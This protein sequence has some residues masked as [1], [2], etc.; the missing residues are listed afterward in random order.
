MMLFWVHLQDVL[1]VP[2]IYQ[3]FLV[4]FYW[5]VFALCRIWLWTRGCQIS[6]FSHSWSSI[7]VCFLCKV[8][9]QPFNPTLKRHQ[10]KFPLTEF[11]CAF[12]F[13]Q[14]Y[15]CE[16]EFQQYYN[17]IFAE[18]F[19]QVVNFHLLIM[20]IDFGYKWNLKSVGFK[21]LIWKL[22]TVDKAKVW[23]KVKICNFY[24]MISIVTKLTRNCLSSQ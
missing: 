17:D 24:I 11:N 6:N 1:N 3:V 4:F 15:W 18:L 10:R 20:V 19:Y 5:D 21:W 23:I 12:R 14:D 8:L 13:N 22:R 9:V 7:W 2:D 16:E